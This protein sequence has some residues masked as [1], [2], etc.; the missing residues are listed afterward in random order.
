MP[1]GRRE[2]RQRVGCASRRGG[3][4]APR[5]R[6][7]FL[8]WLAFTGGAAARAGRAVAGTHRRPE[9]DHPDAGLACC[10]AAL[11]EVSLEPVAGKGRRRWE[12]TIESHHPLG[13]YR[14]PGW[15]LR[16]WIRS[17]ERAILGGIG[18]AA[19]GCQL[20]PRDRFIG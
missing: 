13:W 12:S 14:A 3:S 20:A 11:D 5:R 6:G 15:R 10:L 18:F 1:L 8:S 19:G 9:A 2:R 17:S 4:T 7:F 16:Y